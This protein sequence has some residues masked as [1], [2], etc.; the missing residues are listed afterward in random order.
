MKNLN[1]NGKQMHNWAK[2]LFDFHRSLAGKNNHKTLLYFKNII[3]FLKIK[4]FKSGTKFLDWTIPYEWNIKDAYIKDS[5]GR[6]IIKYQDSNLHIV[7]YSTPIN[8]K[9]NLTNL[10]KHLFSLPDQ[11]NAIPYITSYYK[12]FWGF[13]LTHIQ[14]KKLKKDNYKVFIDSEFKK[15][16]MHYAEVLLKGKV[17]HEI[18]FSTNICHPAMGNNEL[19]GPV[20]TTALLNWLNQRKNN[21]YSYRAI[22]IPETIG[23]IAYLKTNKS[24]L[25]KN[26]IA[27]FNVVCV[28]DDNCYSYMPPKDENSFINKV[29]SFAL[30]YYKINYRLYSFLDRGSDERQ[31]CSQ[32]Y[33]LPVCSLMRSKYNTYPEYHTSLD[34]LN[35]ITPKGLQSSFDLYVK[36]INILEINLYYKC[37][38]IYG[39]PF[40]TKYNLYPLQNTKKTFNSVKNIRNILEYADGSLDLIDLSKKIKIDFFKAYEIVKILKDKGLIKIVN[41]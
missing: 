5:K 27:G 26:I 33:N 17:N 30:S 15:G 39:E 36:I 14:R 37:T 1:L 34:N 23:S 38:Y 22:Y 6:K 24:K 28:G 18:F 13:C 10:N 31:Y 11:P 8:K 7:S 21:Y 40:L 9:I 32:A 4:F 19:S 41:R 35:F 12:N 20:L 16:K 25:K 29:V 3:P 2:E